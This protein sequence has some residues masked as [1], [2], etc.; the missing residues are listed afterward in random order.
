M[1]VQYNSNIKHYF[2]GGYFMN[3]FDETIINCALCSYH[4]MCEDYK[5]VEK[6]VDALSLES[7]NAFCEHAGT[8]AFLKLQWRKSGWKEKLEKIDSLFKSLDL[9]YRAE[10]EPKKQE[11]VKSFFLESYFD[12]RAQAC[13]AFNQKWQEIFMTAVHELLFSWEKEAIE[14]HLAISHECL[15]N[16]RQAL[17]NEKREEELEKGEVVENG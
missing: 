16:K 9:A 1:N 10:S 14:L 3:G 4:S 6:N 15:K 11:I 7:L 2:L 8:M 5:Y 17:K 13:Y 12:I